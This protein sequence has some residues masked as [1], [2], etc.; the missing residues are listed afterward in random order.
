[1]VGNWLASSTG[2]STWDDSL[3]IVNGSV[4]FQNAAFNGAQATMLMRTSTLSDGVVANIQVGGVG[5]VQIVSYDG[6][7]TFSIY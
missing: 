3:F 5:N 2:V 4:S 6:K 1:V 7:Y